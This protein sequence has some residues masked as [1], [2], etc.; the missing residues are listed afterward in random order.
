[1]VLC[2]TGWRGVYRIYRRNSVWAG[3]GVKDYF[4]VN[5]AILRTYGSRLGN[6]ES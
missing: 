4:A 1:V 5:D 3:G 6:W 2:K